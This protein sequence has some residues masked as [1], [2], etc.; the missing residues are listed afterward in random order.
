[1][2]PPDCFDKS[3]HKKHIASNKAST[4][5]VNHEEF[6]KSACDNVSSYPEWHELH[7]DVLK[8][9]ADL[10]TWLPSSIIVNLE[11]PPSTAR[12]VT[13]PESHC[14]T[15]PVLPPIAHLRSPSRSTRERQYISTPP[16]QTTSS[17][18][19]MSLVRAL[20]RAL[21][22]DFM[23]FLMNVSACFFCPFAQLKKV[24]LSC[25]SS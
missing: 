2:L 17:K 25:R 1:M 23:N 10:E 21:G 14:L 6:I 22:R 13:P 16:P 24:V 19:R 8:L 9:G 20:V 11:E 5:I 4:H 3:Y 12:L 18:R 15:S 7:K